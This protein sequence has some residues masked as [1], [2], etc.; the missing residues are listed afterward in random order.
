MDINP[1]LVILFSFVIVLIILFIILNMIG[2]NN[3]SQQR[4]TII[5]P[6]TPDCNVALDSL[7]PIDTNED[8]CCYNNGQLT[9]AYFVS[10]PINGTELGF[11][12]I[13]V[14]TYYINVCRQFC[15]SGY[16]LNT[17]GTIQCNGEN[18]NG[19]QTIQAN[20]CV[21]LIKPEINGNVCN[22]SALPIASRGISPYYAFNADT[23]TG[24][25]Q[26]Q[27]LGPCPLSL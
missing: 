21:Q 27:V 25:A 23:I 11:S 19:N 4:E 12:V 22:G 7:V 18:S 10:V 3:W 5:I 8:I 20:N 9:G 26:C 24:I 2:V 14:S 16:T 13:P 17:N 6:S 15:N 1:P